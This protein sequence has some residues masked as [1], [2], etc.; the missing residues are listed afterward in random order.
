MYLP[1]GT[2][3]RAVAAELQY[4]P[5][6][7]QAAHAVAVLAPEYRPAGQSVQLFAPTPEYLPA[8]QPVQLRPEIL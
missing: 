8:V 4:F 5:L 3:D 2:L 6:A 7:V 1:L